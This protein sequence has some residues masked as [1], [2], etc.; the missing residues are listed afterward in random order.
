MVLPPSEILLLL[1]IPRTVQ[2]FSSTKIQVDYNNTPYSYYK[3][4]LLYTLEREIIVIYFKNIR[5]AR[6][7]KP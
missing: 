3:I 5:N 6:A 2:S 1:D 7:H 4:L